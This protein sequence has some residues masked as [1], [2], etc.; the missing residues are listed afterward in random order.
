MFNKCSDLE[1][2]IK[3]SLSKQAANI[4]NIE[5][6]VGNEETEEYQLYVEYSISGNYHN[7]RLMMTEEKILKTFK[8]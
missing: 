5:V 7:H 3:E 1:Y 8:Y 2:R 6:Y 4:Y